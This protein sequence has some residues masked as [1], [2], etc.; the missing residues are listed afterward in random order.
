MAKNDNKSK[1]KPASSV[2]PTGPDPRKGQRGYNSP[3][4]QNNPKP[5][6]GK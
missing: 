6:R 1:P 2:K 5:K 4:I 3:R